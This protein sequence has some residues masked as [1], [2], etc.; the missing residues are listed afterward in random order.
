MVDEMIYGA[1]DIWRAA[2][3]SRSGAVGVEDVCAGPGMGALARRQHPASVIRR[4]HP[5]MRK[6]ARKAILAPNHASWF[7]KG[8]M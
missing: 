3:Q 7:P 1:A 6:L 4:V 2:I 5:A 8:S